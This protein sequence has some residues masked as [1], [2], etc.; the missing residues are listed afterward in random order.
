VSAW[1]S[2]LRHRLGGYR[3]YAVPAELSRVGEATWLYLPGDRPAPTPH[4]LLP[5]ASVSLAFV[6]RRDGRGR[7]DQPRLV[8]I[9]PITAARLGAFPG[10]HEM[11]AVKLKLEW[12][13][14]L[15]GARPQEHRDRG[16][17][18]AG[19]LPRQAGELE[20]RLTQTRAAGEALDVLARA[21]RD[22]RPRPRAGDEVAAV[23]LDLVRQTG[24]R[25]SMERIADLQGVSTRH[26]RRRVGEVA[27][28]SLREYAREVRLMRALT[29]ADRFVRPPWADLAVQAGFYDQPHLVR[30]CQV[31]CGLPPGRLH[32]ERRLEQV[33]ESSN[34]RA[35]PFS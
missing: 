29:T 35:R 31:V 15:L 24:G 17:T 8:L 5:D 12:V 21:V 32:R 30:D 22:L 28:I 3:Q 14:P 16:D 9:G 4:R 34:P 10:R 18:L 27:G 20:D 13:R 6:C 33:A 25:M 1:R 2:D 26:L 23:A 11:A 7:P 19:L